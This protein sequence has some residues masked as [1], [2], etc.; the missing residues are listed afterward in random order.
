MSR[1]LPSGFRKETS[2]MSFPLTSLTQQALLM[3]L[4]F[5]FTATI[6]NCFCSFL[7]QGVPPVSGLQMWMNGMCKVQ[8]SQCGSSKH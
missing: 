8:L 2:S 3:A 4:P 5:S 7:F 6:N 1:L